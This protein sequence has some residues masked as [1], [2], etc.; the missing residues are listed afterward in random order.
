MSDTF[1]TLFDTALGRCGI[2]WGDKGIVAVSF[3]EASDAKT[4][5]R[6][7]RQTSAARDA[8]ETDPRKADAIPSTKGAL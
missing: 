1:Y 2:A 7:R 8:V 3:P 4:V 5:E 6:L